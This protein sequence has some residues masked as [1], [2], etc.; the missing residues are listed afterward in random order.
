MQ[1]MIRY[2][3]WLLKRVKDKQKKGENELGYN[4]SS[5]EGDIG[6]SKEDCFTQI[7]HNSKPPN[8]QTKKLRLREIRE[9]A[10]DPQAA[11]GNRVRIQNQK[12]KQG[13]ILEGL[14][15]GFCCNNNESPGKILSKE[16][17]YRPP[18]LLS[19]EWVWEGLVRAVRT[20]SQSAGA[21]TTVP[22][23]MEVTVN[24]KVVIGFG[25]YFGCGAHRT[26]H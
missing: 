13:Q 12:S 18:W 23:T 21:E 2:Q 5:L 10:H 6:R 1:H 26:C 19:G 16:V 7:N 3:K 14:E 8:L 17:T 9:F 15:F 4:F 24:W 25:I 11:G 22:W 20:A